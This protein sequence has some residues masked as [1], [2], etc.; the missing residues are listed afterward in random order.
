MPEEECKDARARESK[1]LMA[2]VDILSG[3]MMQCASFFMCPRDGDVFYLVACVSLR[4]GWHHFLC[5][6]SNITY[7]G[8]LCTEDVLH[9]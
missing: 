2:F 3:S 6:S 8:L 1:V 4:G 7:G 9:E 5:K